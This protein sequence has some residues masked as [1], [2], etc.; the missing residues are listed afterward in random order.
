LDPSSRE[1]SGEHLVLYDGVCG[2]CSRVCRFILARDDRHRFD[3]ASLQSPTGRSWLERYGRSADSLDSFCLIANYRTAPALSDRSTAALAVTSGL[4]PP[5]SWL[6]IFR[7]VPAALRDAIYDAIARRR[8]RWFGR[9][10]VCE[11]PSP[12]HRARFLDI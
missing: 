9:S 7:I 8:Y 3:F 11:L 12:D 5:W 2:L 4:G 10:D 1:G 6:S